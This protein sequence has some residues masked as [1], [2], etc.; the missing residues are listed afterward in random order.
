M[1]QTK[2][3][4]VVFLPL[5]IA[6]LETKNI[7]LVP[8]T[9]L[10]GRPDLPLPCVRRKSSLEVEISQFAFSGTELRVCREDLAPVLVSITEAAVAMMGRVLWWRVCLVGYQ[11]GVE[12]GTLGSG[13]G[14]TLGSDGVCTLRI[15]EGVFQYLGEGVVV[16]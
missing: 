2:L 8:S 3:V 9:R 10:D 13:R 12:V 14:F 7:V 4:H 5:G 15:D 1:S 16:G 11:C 6:C